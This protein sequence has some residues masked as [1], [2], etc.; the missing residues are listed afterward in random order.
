MF[1]ELVGQ[2]GMVGF[3]DRAKM[4]H[5]FVLTNPTNDKIT[6]NKKLSLIET[7]SMLD[8]IADYDQR[9]LPQDDHGRFI[10]SKREISSSFKKQVS[11]ILNKR[12]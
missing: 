6:T 11:K 2:K 10:I 7:E 1:I 8:N 5:E 4:I 9:G 12:K 3:D